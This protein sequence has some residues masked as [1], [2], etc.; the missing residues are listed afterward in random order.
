MLHVNTTST[1]ELEPPEEKTKP[2]PFRSVYQIYVSKFKNNTTTNKIIKHVIDK[3]EV[4]NPDLFSVELLVKPKENI[5][6]LSYV[7]FKISTC[8][9]K[10]YEAF[11]NENVWSLNFTATPFL[12]QKQQTMI[13]NNGNG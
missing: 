7:S 10:V 12:D 6:K 1:D 9:E 13:G 3:S 4:K 2:K 8:S 5:Q 11:L